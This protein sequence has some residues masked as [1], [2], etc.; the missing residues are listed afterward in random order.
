MYRTTARHLSIQ[1]KRHGRYNTASVSVYT[2][3]LRHRFAP[4][5]YTRESPNTQASQDYNGAQ[6]VSHF[7]QRFEFSL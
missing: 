3:K 1:A 6:S 4:A 5:D 2:F 7:E